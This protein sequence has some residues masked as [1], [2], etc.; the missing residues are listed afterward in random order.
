MK[1]Y[2]RKESFFLVLL[3]CSL[4]ILN[5]IFYYSLF[6]SSFVSTF[7]FFVIVRAVNQRSPIHMMFLV[8]FSTFIYIPAM[9]NLFFFNTSLDLYFA[10]S[11]VS[12]VFLF[13]TYSIIY[14]HIKYTN[15]SYLI[16]FLIFSALVIICSFFGFST[17][18]FMS[19]L[20]MFYVLSMKPNY[21][22]YNILISSLFI[23]VFAIFLLIGWSGYGRTVTFGILITAFLYFLYVNEI[24]FNKLFFALFPVLGSL[25]LVSR[26]DLSLSIDSNEIVNDS[27][28][29]P[30]RLASTFI[31]NYLVKGFDFIGFFDQVV[32]SLLVFVPR[33][34]WPSKPYG[35]GFQYVVDNMEQSF[36]DEGHS[37]ASTL[38]G[39]HIYFLGWWGILTALIMV[40]MIYKICLFV[41]NMKLFQGFGIVIISCSIMVILWGGMTSF[42]ARII[43]PILGMIP[44]F[45][46]YGL[47]L[48]LRN[49]KF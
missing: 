36:V 43:L 49:R 4:I 37:I 40:Y 38:I 12:L 10:T 5:K 27:A 39:D 47:F 19:P 21:Y 26:K 35:F 14:K 7:I 9:V 18:Y 32:F 2:V 28:I 17:M 13:L 30:Y 34:L 45:L 44:V 20:V 42:S 25:M 48:I 29:G 1:V 3:L 31:D 22:L 16:L 24:K 23:S 8:G 11:F 33:D 41:N 46:L 6:F 15:L